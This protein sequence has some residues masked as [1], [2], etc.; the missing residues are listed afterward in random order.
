MIMGWVAIFFPAF[1]V[2]L[3]A[4]SVL[5][6]ADAAPVEAEAGGRGAVPEADRAVIV[7]IVRTH[8][9]GEDGDQG[10]PGFLGLAGNGLGNPSCVVAEV[11]SDIRRLLRSTA[12]RLPPAGSG[13]PAQVQVAGPVLDDRAGHVAQFQVVAARIA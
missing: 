12:F 2:R 11:R 8:I 9:A 13:H 10:A 3:L 7:P 6:D 4:F 1:G 5:V